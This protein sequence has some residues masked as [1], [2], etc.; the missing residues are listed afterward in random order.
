MWCF[1]PSKVAQMLKGTVTEIVIFFN[2]FVGQNKIKTTVF[3]RVR[4][5]APETSCSLFLNPMGN[6]AVGNRYIRD[7]VDK[8]RGHFLTFI[9]GGTNAREKE[10]GGCKSSEERPKSLVF[11]SLW[12][13]YKANQQHGPGDSTTRYRIVPASADG[14]HQAC[15]GPCSSG[16][17]LNLL[18]QPWTD[19]GVHTCMGWGS[20][21]SQ[22][23]LHPT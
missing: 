10:S 8:C 23:S 7:A 20:Q 3:T 5:R 15:P 17:L 11:Q 16:P 22:K 1:S 6:R 18:G 13:F 12:L 2:L 21:R 19:I 4:A 14:Q 9:P